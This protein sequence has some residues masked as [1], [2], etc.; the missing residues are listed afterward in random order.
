MI[1]HGLLCKAQLNLDY[2]RKQL[3]RTHSDT[4]NACP[5]TGTEIHLAGK[6]LGTQISTG[7]FKELADT[8]LGKDKRQRSN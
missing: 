8:A 5:S 1:K 2:V 6:Y 3:L 4:A 7:Q